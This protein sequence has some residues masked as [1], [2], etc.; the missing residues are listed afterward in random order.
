MVIGKENAQGG[1]PDTRAA[2]DEEWWRVEKHGS[3]NQGKTELSG[4]RITDYNG[5]NDGWQ[6]QE[7]V[8]ESRYLVSDH[9]S[10]SGPAS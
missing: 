7:Q 6:Y 3:D 2:E 1:Q 10:F 9:Y 4:T 8:V 5:Q